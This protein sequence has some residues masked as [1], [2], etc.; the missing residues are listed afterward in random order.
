MAVLLRPPQEPSGGA[1]L[2]TPTLVLCPV[3]FCVRARRL[4][5]SSSP[6]PPLSSVPFYFFITFLLS[7]SPTHIPSS[8]PTRCYCTG[9]SDSTM[10]VSTAPG[11][12]MPDR[13]VYQSLASYSRSLH[14]Y[15]LRL[16]TES[17]EKNRGAHAHGLCMYMY[18]PFTNATAKPSTR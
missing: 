4:L 10:I 2:Y 15:T 16:W 13:Q 1:H 7:P 14:Q 3:Y 9:N 18:F 6:T 8:T 17:R 11:T 12:P 5:F